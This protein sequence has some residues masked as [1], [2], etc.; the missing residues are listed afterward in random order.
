MEKKLVF[1]ILNNEKS[2]NE[3]NIVE[4]IKDDFYIW[5]K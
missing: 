2:Y 5:I 3:F 1:Y 4:M